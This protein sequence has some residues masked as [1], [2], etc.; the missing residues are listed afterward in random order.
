MNRKQ[1]LFAG[2]LVLFLIVFMS[3]SCVQDAI[4]PT[5]IEPD[6]MTSN[7]ASPVNGL[8]TTLFDAKQLQKNVIHKLEYQKL[9]AKQAQ[10]DLSISVASGEEIKDVIFDP[11]GPLALMLPALAG[12]G[13]GRYLR[14]PN[15]KKVEEELVQLKANKTNS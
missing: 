2:F 10:E 15:E 12:L 8:Y 5:Y 11:T 7:N 14:S 6:L 9:V 1:K 4:V 13:L 3:A